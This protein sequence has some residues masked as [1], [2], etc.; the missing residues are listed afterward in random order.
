MLCW[1]YEG[2]PQSSAYFF[3]ARWLTFVILSNNLW[4]SEEFGMIYTKEFV[5]IVN[6]HCSFF[7][8]KSRKLNQEI[9]ALRCS[10]KA[11]EDQKW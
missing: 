4:Y 7:A 1:I 5:F 3:G 6:K 2:N 8:I 11:S 9:C 10:L